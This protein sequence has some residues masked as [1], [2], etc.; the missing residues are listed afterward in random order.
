MEK[1]T[2]DQMKPLADRIAAVDAAAE[3]LAARIDSIRKLV[4]GLHDDVMDLHA[5]CAD[6]GVEV[7]LLRARAKGLAS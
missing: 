4:A 7:G 3:L 5:I 2:P 6:L 1:G